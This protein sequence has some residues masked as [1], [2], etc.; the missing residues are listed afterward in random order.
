MIEAKD[1]ALEIGGFLGDW[2]IRKAAWSSQAH[3]KANAASIKKIY[4]F[5]LE[6]GEID[7]TELAELKVII[8]ENMPDWLDNIS[9]YLD[10]DDWDW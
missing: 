10:D 6:K 1:G 4:T 9:E 7:K 3:I 8:K 2:F 5:L